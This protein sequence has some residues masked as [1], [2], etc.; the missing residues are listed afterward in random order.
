MKLKTVIFLILF[1]FFVFILT[2][3]ITKVSNEDKSL[4]I[5]SNVDLYAEKIK[6]YK[7]VITIEDSISLSGNCPQ[8]F[9]P[10]IKN[11]NRDHKLADLTGPYRITKKTFNDSIRVIIESDTLYYRFISMN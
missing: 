2:I 4:K 7:G 9:D 1:L 5:E 3:L 6:Y 8:I 11:L 10:K